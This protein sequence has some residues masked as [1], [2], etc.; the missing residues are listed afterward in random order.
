MAVL[1]SK[2]VL[3][4]NNTTDPSSITSLTLTHKALSDVQFPVS[5]L[6]EFENLQKLDLGF[7]NLTS[8]EGLK[9]CANLKWLS[10]LQNK[11]Q[12]LKG[13]EGLVKLTNILFHIYSC[14]KDAFSV[15]ASSWHL[16]DSGTYRSEDWGAWTTIISHVRMSN[17]NFSMLEQEMKILVKS[18]DIHLYFWDILPRACNHLPCEPN[19]F[20][21]LLNRQPLKWGKIESIL[22]P[23]SSLL[24]S[25]DGS[26]AER[27]RK[28]MHRSTMS[29]KCMDWICFTLKEA[30][31]DKGKN[32]RKWKGRDVLIIPEIA[33][34]AGWKEIAFKI[35]RA[36]GTPRPSIKLMGQAG[37]AIS[38]YQKLMRAENELLKRSLV[39]SFGLGLKES[40]TLSKTMVMEQSKVQLKW[41][42]RT[43]GASQIP[44]KVTKT[45]IKAMES[46]FIRGHPPRK[47]RELKNHPKWARIRWRMTEIL[48]KR[49]SHNSRRNHLLYP[50]LAE[51]KARFKYHLSRGGSG[52]RRRCRDSRGHNPHGRKVL[53]SWWTD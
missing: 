16:V 35:E 41:W 4:D 33:L 10:V 36:N 20:L 50:D 52:W 28:M 11:L 13:I 47:N 53:D 27:S 19:F 31:H 2:Q 25:L 17:Y 32:P 24:T 38:P 30:S 9:L 26:A 48:T 42:S 34:N 39:G 43:V 7:N 3:K 29:S 46:L 22:T 18:A 51:S 21:V 8:L 5:C 12:S 15:L 37:K 44:K 45:R 49:G 23:V 40:P 14:R 6:S 1:S